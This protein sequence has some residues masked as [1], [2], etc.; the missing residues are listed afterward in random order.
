MEKQKT[1]HFWKSLILDYLFDNGY[2]NQLITGL[3][4]NPR[5]DAARIVLFEELNNP[6]LNN[7]RVRVVG[8]YRLIIIYYL[9]RVE[10]VVN[11]L[12]V[13]SQDSIKLSVHIMNNYDNQHESFLYIEV[14]GV[15]NNSSPDVLVCFK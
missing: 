6:A 3:R 12:I 15:L 1:P 10:S 7:K 14:F 2:M 11:D 8:L 5:F 4:R 13:I 9:C